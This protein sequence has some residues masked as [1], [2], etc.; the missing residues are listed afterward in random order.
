MHYALYLLISIYS[1]QGKTYV[2]ALY[3]YSLTMWTIS[4]YTGGTSCSTCA[5]VLECAVSGLGA[6][7]WNGSAFNCQETN[8]EIVLLHNRYN[9]TDGTIH[10]CNGGAILAQSTSFKNNRYTS[11]LQ[12]NVSEEILEKTIGCIYDNGS[13]EF[14][15]L[16]STVKEGI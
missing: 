12:I 15:V 14:R 9:S 5:T 4:I 3:L 8:N 13:T 1:I 10:T 7:V 6:T 11:R 16:T 2:Q